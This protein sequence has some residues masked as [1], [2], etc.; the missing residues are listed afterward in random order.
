MLG[1]SPSR[2][3]VRN[4]LG[5]RAWPLRSSFGIHVALISIMALVINA[6]CIF[7]TLGFFVVI[8]QLAARIACEKIGSLQA[9]GVGTPDVC[10]SLPSLAGGQICGWQALQTCYS[11]TNMRVAYIVVGAIMQLWCHLIWLIVLVGSL[12]RS[13]TKVA[14]VRPGRHA[15]D[16]QKD[17]VD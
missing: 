4:Y 2:R 6:A 3:S 13:R 14:V 7:V 16:G 10:I 9:L 11:V 12:E 15:R 8:T 1:T 17:N 5:G